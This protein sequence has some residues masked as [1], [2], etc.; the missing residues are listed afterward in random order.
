M[1]Q[2][3]RIHQHLV[4]PLIWREAPEGLYPFPLFWMEGKKDMEGFGGCF[5][6][7]FVKEPTQFMPVDGGQLVHS[8]DTVLV[9][10]SLNTDD[11]LD[12]GAQIE[13]DIGE[14]R[15]TY[16]FDKSQAVCIPKGTPYG[17]V[18]VKKVDR[19]FAHFVMSLD[20][21]YTFMHIPPEQLK[22]PVPGRK[23]EGF[24]RIF[25]WGVDPKTGRPLHSGGA[26]KSQ[27]GSGMG[28][29]NFVDERGVMHPRNHGELGPGNADN[30]VWLYGDELQNFNLNFLFGH[31]SK[32][33][34]WHRG[35]ESHS[36]PQE[37]ILIHT[38]LDPDDPFNI[39]ACIE[40]A[41]GEEDERY[42]CTVPTVYIQPK[43]F[44]HLPQ[45]TRW[46]DKP[47]AFMVMN[48]D[49]THDSPWKDRDGS[50]TQYED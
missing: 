48:L 33:G 7:T 50:K 17:P 37:E 34:V 41:M 29:V 19:P 18:R 13:V 31:Y 16:S 10:V 38:G 28:Y 47:Y 44:S 42:A 35:G 12:L 20:P 8:F 45:I 46:V 21:E 14:E 5:S 30:M 24:A 1:A 25:A 15:E 2:K 40:I 43:G 49:G 22:E 26:D 36:H 3:S 23:Y 11:I 9:F 39:G 32:E 27:D 6:F 4:K